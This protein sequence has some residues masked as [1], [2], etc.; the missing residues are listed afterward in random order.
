VAFRSSVAGA[1]AAVTA[2]CNRYTGGSIGSN[3]GCAS[4][5]AAIVTWF[6]S[7]NRLN[8]RRL[9]VGYG[10]GLFVP[11]IVVRAL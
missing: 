1:V 9:Y 11:R 10:L 7:G 3:V 8:G 5:G 2:L 4:A 6:L